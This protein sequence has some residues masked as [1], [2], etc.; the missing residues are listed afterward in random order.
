MKTEAWVESFCLRTLYTGGPQTSVSHFGTVGPRQVG[1]PSVDT[2]L[3]NFLWGVVPSI[4]LWT[5]PPSC[6][7]FHLFLWSPLLGLRVPSLFSAVVCG[8]P[9]RLWIATVHHPTPRRAEA[10]SG[11]DWSRLVPPSQSLR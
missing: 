9:S 1:L 3:P 5:G 7:S 6:H 11:P 4:R 8:V 10:P 2:D